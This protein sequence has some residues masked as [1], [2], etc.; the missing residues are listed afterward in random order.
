MSLEMEMELKRPPEGPLLRQGIHRL[1]T[2]H[3]H[4]GEQIFFCPCA[5]NWR[6]RGID[7]ATATA[8]FLNHSQTTKE[9]E[10]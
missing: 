9:S 2:L 7:R 4:T 1:E 10:Y 8:A 5:C 6:L 3:S